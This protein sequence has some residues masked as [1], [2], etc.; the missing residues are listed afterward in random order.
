MFAQFESFV[1]EVLW[2]YPILIAVGGFLNS[3]FTRSH[4][5]DPA[6]PTEF[7]EATV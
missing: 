1:Y 2:G 7:R 3:E 6:F 4:L 5:Y